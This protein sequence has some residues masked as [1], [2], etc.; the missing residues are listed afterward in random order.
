LTVEIE[1]IIIIEETML[2]KSNKLYL[3]PSLST[4]T[5]QPLRI[6]PNQS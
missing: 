1:F 3:G 2:K 6:I 4:Q 5:L